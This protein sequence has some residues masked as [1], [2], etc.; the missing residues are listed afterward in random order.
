MTNIT[1]DASTTSYPISGLEAGIRYVIMI[2]ASTGAGMGP[3]SASVDQST[4]AVPR[5]ISAAGFVVDMDR[6]D[7]TSITV[8]L[9]MIDN[10]ADTFRLATCMCP[11]V[12]VCVCAWYKYVCHLKEDYFKLL[13]IFM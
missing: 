2:A 3:F 10:S 11:Y 12:C 8:T 9:P 5:N 1:V 6:V 13:Y 4:I 7:S